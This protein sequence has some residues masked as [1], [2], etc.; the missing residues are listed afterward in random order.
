M[1]EI[2]CEWSMVEFQL[3]T[4]EGRYFRQHIEEVGGLCCSERQMH[5][6]C[7]VGPVQVQRRFT[8]DIRYC[9]FSFS[10]CLLSFSRSHDYCVCAKQRKTLFQENEIEIKYI[11]YIHTHKSRTIRIQHIFCYPCNHLTTSIVTVYLDVV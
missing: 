1:L 6:K 9:L 5:G 8:G 2:Q 4:L 3:A 10:G 11:H 7:G